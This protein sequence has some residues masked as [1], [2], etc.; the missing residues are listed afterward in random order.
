[1]TDKVLTIK[2]YLN[3]V[4]D[5]DRLPSNELSPV[6]HG[7]FGEVGGLMAVAKKIKREPDSFTGFNSV[8]VEEFGDAFWYLCC[9]ARRLEIDIENVFITV[10]KEGQSN[11]EV[12]IG[13]EDSPVSLMYKNQIERDFDEVLVNLGQ[14][15][16]NFL[17]PDFIKEESLEKLTSFL[18]TFFSA[19]HILKLNFSKIIQWNLDKISSRFIMPDYS[20]LPTFDDGF[21]EYERLP[22]EFEIEFVQRTETQQAMQWNGVFIGDP[23]TDSIMDEDGY[24]FHDVFHFSFA[25]ILHWSP[26]FRALIKHKRKSDSDVDKNQDGGRAIVVEEGLSAWI[27][28]IAK[29]NNFFE[30]K[31]NLTFDMLKNVGQFVKGYEVDKCPLILWELAILEGYKVFRSVKDNNG[32][33]VV[34]DRRNRTIGYR[35]N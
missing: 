31:K 35:E 25:S 23:L 2:D 21:P 4:E 1:M 6:L 33:V 32:G 18:K 7:L 29:E 3:F 27:F 28:T 12:L 20:Y 34:C 13:N 14:L 16:G 8:V 15:T 22:D 17:N 24:R 26:T 10:V 11:P 30:D 19:L 9:L 5:T